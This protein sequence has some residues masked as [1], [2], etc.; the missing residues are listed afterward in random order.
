[1]IFNRSKGNNRKIKVCL[2]LQ[3]YV[4]VRVVSIKIIAV[5]DVERLNCV[6]TK[7]SALMLDVLL[8]YSHRDST[9][10]KPK[11]A[12]IMMKQKEKKWNN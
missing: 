6:M 3:E 11:I 8:V 12:P 1:M 9:K 7:Y 4:V 2:P 5:W 10:Q